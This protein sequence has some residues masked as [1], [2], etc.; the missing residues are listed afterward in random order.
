MAASPF[1]AKQ[2]STELLPDTPPVPGE[3]APPDDTALPDA[4]PAKPPSR[5]NRLIKALGKINPF[6]NAR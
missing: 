3:V 4:A 6:R 5:G 2:E 1:A